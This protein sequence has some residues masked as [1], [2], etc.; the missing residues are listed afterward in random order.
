[1]IH[2]LQ[3]GPPASSLARHGTILG[4]AAR[5]TAATGPAL[6]LRL[7]GEID[8]RRLTG[9][10][11]LPRSRRGQAMLAIL[12]L[13]MPRPV[14]RAQL[15]GLLWPGRG[16]EQARASLRQALHDLTEALGRDAG[17][18]LAIR[19][20]TIALRAG[21]VWTDVSELQRG[22]PATPAML[23]L[24]AGTVL[25]DFSGLT[26][27]FDSWLAEARADFAARGRAIAEAVLDHATDTGQVLAAARRLTEF[28][29][30]HEGGWRAIMRA[31]AL[32]GER[33]LALLAFQECE[34]ALSVALGT[35]PAAATRSLMEQIQGGSAIPPPP[36]EP[37]LAPPPRYS[38]RGARLG[39]APLRALG[40]GA[41]DAHLSLGL[42]EEIATALSRFRW[43]PL[44]APQSLARFAEGGEDEQSLRARFDL[45]LLLAGTVQ[46]AEGTVR[47]TLRLSDLRS[48][49]ELVWA[50][51][52]DR[53]AEN[54]LAMQDEIAAAVVARI[55]PELLLIE[56]RRAAAQPVRDSAAYDL[57]L[58][59][60]PAIHRLE[61]KSFGESGRLL[62]EAIARE[63]DYAAAHAWF[64][65]WH[66][67]Q[68]GQGW[69]R[70]PDGAMRRAGELAERAITLDP[71]DARALTIA[72]HVRG[73][74]HRQV[75]EAIALHERA[76]ALNPNLPMAW[77]FSGLARA[78]HG[79]HEEALVR[80]RRWKLLSPMDPHA[81]LYI[82]TE[83]VPQLLLGRFEE[84]IALGR[85]AIE[86]HP[87][88]SAHYRPFLAAL[89]QLGRHAH[90]AA[91]RAKFLKLEPR[92]T[93]AKFLAAA[94]YVREEDR[95]CFA[96]GLRKAGLPE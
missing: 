77:V 66:V 49:G 15:I 11:A 40:A 25:E 41:E 85:M 26:P 89:G 62:E 1:M 34:R 55:D 14:P 23:S 33:S 78:Y 21:S 32:G 2:E 90:A 83:M 29:P 92:F 86:A 95:R 13:A 52:F 79:E 3:A 28:D 51:R 19:D 69:A 74:L 60:I 58:R 96:E 36:P 73:Y 84:V 30:T 7:I 43:I 94:P 68:V 42:A 63:P 87:N 47:V 53:A 4:L 91:A 44:V 6:R 50:Q 88:L 75:D 9:E 82:G 45:D 8:A 16:E 20:D 39:V 65:L 81:H 72:G 35:R 59:A 24:L 64:A 61:E 22:G 48:Q 17:A 71:R 12:A 27:A 76:L 80:I 46:R 54:I 38:T 67:F 57:L 5:E 10:R 18:I 93:I 37:T 70:D 56:A 31:H